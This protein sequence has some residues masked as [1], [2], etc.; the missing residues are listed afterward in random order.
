[1]FQCHLYRC[2]IENISM[3]TLKLSQCYLHLHFTSH[4]TFEKLLAQTLNSLLKA[5]V[6]I[7]PV[8]EFNQEFD[9][10]MSNQAIEEKFQFPK[11]YQGSVQSVW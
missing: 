11:R 4:T 9:R 2:F 5:T 7:T 1:M 8:A 6:R 10:K 3:K